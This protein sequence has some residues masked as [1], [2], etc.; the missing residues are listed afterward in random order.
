VPT[1]SV[2]TASWLTAEVMD[3]IDWVFRMN[4]EMVDAWKDGCRVPPTTVHTFDAVAAIVMNPYPW[5]IQRLVVPS[6]KVSGE[7]VST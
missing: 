3:E 7:F 2:D 6:S 1:E 4:V 5:V